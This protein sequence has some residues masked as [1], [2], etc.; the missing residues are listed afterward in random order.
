MQGFLELIFFNMGP[1]IIRFYAKFKISEL[2]IFKSIMG[3]GD[4][5]NSVTSV[6]LILNIERQLFHFFYLKSWMG[7]LIHK[8]LYIHFSNEEVTQKNWVIYS[9]K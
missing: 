4:K 8:P 2:S 1:H 7:S 6:F 3:Q 5:N 9:I